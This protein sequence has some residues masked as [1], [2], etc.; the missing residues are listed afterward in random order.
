MP[1]LSLACLRT[2]IR[3]DKALSV[4]LPPVGMVGGPGA[5]AVTPPGGWQEPAPQWPVCQAPHPGSPSRPQRRYRWPPRWGPS[6]PGRPTL[7]CIGRTHA[8]PTQFSI[9]STGESFYS[10]VRYAIPLHAVTACQQV[11]GVG[12]DPW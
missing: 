3:S 7:S 2:S 8:P 6:L 1:G 9:S 11:T 5:G 10:L 4:N 12:K